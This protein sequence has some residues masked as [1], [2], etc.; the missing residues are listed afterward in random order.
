MSILSI[1]GTEAIR[2]PAQE[3]Y[4]KLVDLDFIKDGIP[5]A[6]STTVINADELRCRIRPG[7]SFL[8]GTLDVILNVTSRE[9]ASAAAMKVNGKAMGATVELDTRMQVRPTGDGSSCEVDWTSDVIHLGGLLKM[10][11]KGMI[12][13]LAAKV[14][15]KAWQDIRERIEN[16]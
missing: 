15:R 8:K 1:S 2:R 12:E 6:E 9:P 4:Q 11:S 10:V 5:D 7:V 13:G 3:V 16:S 14:S